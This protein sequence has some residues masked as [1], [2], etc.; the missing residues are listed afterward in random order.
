MKKVIF[1][2]ILAV[3]F[4]TTSFT[5]AHAVSRTDPGAQGGFAIARLVVATGIENREPTGVADSFPASVGKVVCFLEAV[6]IAADVQVT[7]AWIHEGN[8]VLSTPLQLRA[9]SRW[10]TN[11]D[12]NLYDMKGAWRVEVRDASGNVVKDVSFTVE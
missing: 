2:S 8:V 5:S 11:A 7:F 12:K 1:F 4:T 9:G 6:N 3:F 10:R